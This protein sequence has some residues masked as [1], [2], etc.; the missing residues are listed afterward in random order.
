MGEADPAR[1]SYWPLAGF[2]ALSFLPGSV[3]AL[4][5]ATGPWYESLDKP[6][7]NPPSW[8]FG[9]AWTV[10]YILIGISAFL[11]WRARGEK[12]G[13]IAWGVAWALNFAWTPL[14][15]G[16][17]QIGPALAVIIGLAGAIMWTMVAFRR[18]SSASAWLLAPYLA[19][20][21]FATSLNAGILILNR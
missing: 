17:R 11:Y 1:K 4:F 16:A 7:W 8:L 6:P 9:P 15:F 10:L 14:F 3:G 5:T 18:A 20:V 19:W 12:R 2:I 21:L 13:W